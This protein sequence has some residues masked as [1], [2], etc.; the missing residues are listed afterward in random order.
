MSPWPSGP[1]PGSRY[2]PPT[3][4]AT[5]RTTQ[6]SPCYL[7]GAQ[8]GVRG[9]GTAK[10]MRQPLTP[11]PLRTRTPRLA[12]PYLCTWTSTATPCSPSPG[13]CSTLT[14]VSRKVTLILRSTEGQKGVSGQVEPQG[15]RQSFPT[16]AAEW[17]SHCLGPLFCGLQGGREQGGHGRPTYQSQWSG[18]TFPVPPGAVVAQRARAAHP[19]GTPEPAVGSWSCM[20]PSSV[21]QQPLAL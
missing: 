8:A 7:S 9:R 12:C 11:P 10:A 18:Q 16:G 3:T 2:G 20:R 4:I 14:T 1:I 21:S 5:T 13:E 19:E 17:P 15:S 6:N